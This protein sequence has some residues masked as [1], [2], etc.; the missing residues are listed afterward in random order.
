M[1]ESRRPLIIGWEAAKANA[2][3]RFRCVCSCLSWAE[4]TFCKAGTSRLMTTLPMAM[5]TSRGSLPKT[6]SAMIGSD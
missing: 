6:R 1:Q 3:C 5:P 2:M 4:L